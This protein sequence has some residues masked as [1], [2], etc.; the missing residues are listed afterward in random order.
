MVFS[1]SQSGTDIGKTN[2]LYGVQ[3]KWWRDNTEWLNLNGW[4]QMRQGLINAGYNP[5]LA[6]GSSPSQAP[7]NTGQADSSIS[8]SADLVGYGNA[9]G[10]TA[11]GKAT[12]GNLNASTAQQ[13]ANSIKL[14]EEALT[15]E[16]YRN[17]LDSDTALKNVQSEEI[18]RL[19]P[20]REKKLI[21]ETY[22][23]Y[24]IGRLNNTTASYVGYNA[25]SGRISSNAASTSAETNKQWTPAKVLTGLAGAVGLGGL[26]LV[27][28]GKNL[29]KG[30]KTVNQI[31]KYKK[32]NK[33]ASYYKDFQGT[34][35]H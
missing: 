33:S 8:R 32:L 12:I 34:T 28:K 25:E 3:S 23:D 15:Q 4:Q 13:Q 5:L 19:L 21:A 11:F 22:A 17:N 26:G 20:F 16:N 18:W 10:S 29:L 30:Y 31:K 24:A 27:A 14:L 35:V 9:V 6:I 2:K 7:M 1:F